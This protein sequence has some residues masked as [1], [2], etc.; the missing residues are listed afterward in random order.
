[1][2]LTEWEWNNVC[3][4]SERDGINIH[5]FLWKFIV[6]F[7]LR[8]ALWN[9]LMMSLLVSICECMC[10]STAVITEEEREAWRGNFF[11]VLSLFL[12]K[13][14]AIATLEAEA[15]R[16][17]EGVNWGSARDLVTIATH[18]GN[19]RNLQKYM[20]CYRLGERGREKREQM[21]WERS[22][23]GTRATWTEQSTSANQKLTLVTIAQSCSRFEHKAPFMHKTVDR[24]KTWQTE[25][26][27]TLEI[28]ETAM[29][30]KNEWSSR[31]AINVH[32]H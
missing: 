29:L 15:E 22:Q 20:R 32:M 19:G 9:K 11:F 5:W 23:G 16:E 7:C 17:G 3:A 27:C 24:S 13:S 14:V 1:M 18:K 31:N 25:N 6:F 28:A 10:E 30:T 2:N 26:E 12:N 21:R 8:C 4:R